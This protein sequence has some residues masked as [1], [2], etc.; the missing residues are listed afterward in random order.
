MTDSEA[1]KRFQALLEIR[2]KSN[3]P[4]CGR[5]I[6]RGDLAWNGGCTEAGTDFTWVEIQCQGCDTEIAGFLNWYPCCE[7]S[8]ELVECVLEDPWE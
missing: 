5:A 1:E 8:V 4:T 3:C 6:D 2:G 7:T